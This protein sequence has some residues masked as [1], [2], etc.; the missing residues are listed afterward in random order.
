[1]APGRADIKSYK[2]AIKE[3]VMKYGDL[4]LGQLEALVNRLGGKENALRILSCR[5]LYVE[6]EEYDSA[7]IVA[8][9]EFKIWKTIKLHN[10]V[11]ESGSR[12]CS[13]IMDRG[14]RLGKEARDILC[15]KDFIVPTEPKELD[16]VL[17]TISSLGIAGEWKY[18]T[19]CDRAR[20]LGL[21]LCPAEV[22][23][24]LRMAYSDQ[25]F[26]EVV[27]V[28]MEAIANTTG[29]PRIF[30]VSHDREG[31]GKWLTAFTGTWD[32][33]WR[34]DRQFVFVLPKK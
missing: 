7:T 10:T 28:G 5:N 26:G 1:M 33:V 21:E 11:Y 3:I 9:P 22:G 24:W 15:R 31:G 34:C 32:Y 18:S 29:N 20:K 13:A 19:I 27:V 14:F 30:T 8:V 12:L 6:L 4:T 17:L 2:L 25:P 23:P 16:L